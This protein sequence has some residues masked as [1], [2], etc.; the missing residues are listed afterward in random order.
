MTPLAS[1]DTRKVDAFESAGYGIGTVGFGQRPAVVVVD[2][3]NAFTSSRSPIGGGEHIASAVE[4]A[5]PV[6]ATARASGVPVIHTYVAWSSEGEFGR[7]KI[8]SLRE[9]TPGS[10]PAQ[11]DPRVWDRT[12]LCLLKRYPSAF[13]G[14]DLSSILQKQGIDTVLVMGA[15]TSGCVR[16]TTID[17]FSHGFRTHVVEDCC[18]D[19]AP[20]SHEGNLRDVGRRY[21]DIIDSTRAVQ[22]LTSLKVRAAT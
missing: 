22:W 16:A 5:K 15:T 7:W 2:F 8:P 9:I 17:A 13:F 14:T 19:Q 4:R 11:I 12:D 6:L 20:E 21:A 10:W 1:S 3:Q 18:G